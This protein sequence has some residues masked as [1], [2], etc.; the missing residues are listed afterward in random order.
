MRHG[1]LEPVT[2]G[3]RA[4]GRIVQHNE[5]YLETT[6]QDRKASGSYYTPDYIVRYIVEQT[7]GPVLE[8]RKALFK[9]Q[10]DSARTIQTALKRNN[11][12]PAV[13]ILHGQL[14]DTHS[15]AIEA[16]LDIKVLDPAM[17]SGHFLV[18]AVNYLSDQIIAILRDYS[19]NPLLPKLA[20]MRGNIRKSLE[21]Q[22]LKAD[23]V[24]D[25]KLKD[26]VLLRRMVMK[27]CIYGVDLND[28]AVELAKLSL[29]L[30]SFAVGAPLS[31]LDHH[32]RW[33]NSLIG[34]W[35]VEINILPAMGYW[36]EFMRALS[37]MVSITKLTDSTND[38]VHE[39][40][41]LYKQAQENLRPF[42]ER[43]NVDLARHFID[44]GDKGKLAQ[45]QRVARDKP[46]ERAGKHD[47]A[48]I[49][50]FDMAQQ[51]AA[52]RRFFHWKLEFPEVFIDHERSDWK[53]ESTSGFDAVVGNPP[54]IRESGN[55]SIFSYFQKSD[56][57]LQYYQ[58]KTDIYFYFTIQALWL[59]NE[60]GGLGYIIPAN[61]L[62]A[63]SSVKLRKFL[64]DNSQIQSIVVF[65][66]LQVF[67]DAAVE[68]LIIITNKRGKADTF[69]YQFRTTKHI[70]A[71]D[72]IL[73]PEV[74]NI[75][76]SSL[77]SDGWY[78]KGNS[79]QGIDTIVERLTLLSLNL[80]EFFHVEAGVNTGA[81]YV[82]TR[83][84]AHWPSGIQQGQ[85]IFV[86]DK[87]ELV[88]IQFSKIERNYIR[89]YIPPEYVDRYSQEED[90][91][92]F[93][94]YLKRDDD[95]ENLPYIKN[96]LSKFKSI[97]ENRAEILRNPSRRWWHLLWPR[98]QE[99]YE[100]PEKLVIANATA[101]NSFYVDSEQTYYNI[102][103]T[104]LSILANVSIDTNYAAA[105][106]NAKLLD[107]WYELRGQT[108]AET[109]RKYFPDKVRQIPIRR[110]H[111]TTPAARRTALAA[112][113]TAEALA[114]AEQERTLPLEHSASGWPRYDA[115]AFRSA[116][117]GKRIAALLPQDTQGTFLAFADGAT[118]S[119]EQSDVVHDLLAALAKRMIDLNKQKQAE[120]KRFL[121]DLETKL[122]ITT[123][124]NGRTGIDS[125]NKK[126]T[127]Q[128]YLGDYQK[129]EPAQPWETICAVLHKN[130]KRFV[131]DGW[132]SNQPQIFEGA[133][134]GGL[135]RL[136]SEYQASLNKLRPIKRQL[137]RT[138]ALIDQIVYMLY[139]L[140]LEEI[141]V[142][143]A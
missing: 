68:P 69:L 93:L 101:R 120:I 119:E 103:C 62:E 34:I 129:N 70:R 35:D 2:P 19:D 56:H 18:A 15:A 23:S 87:E 77:K 84:R 128:N 88:Q 72:V 13:R 60:C 54:Y 78:L 1:K 132:L 53:A 73:S 6:R 33:G 49:A 113:L 39:S 48:S 37:A 30:D 110:I 21:A 50:R 130:R 131:N 57:F 134:S 75:P 92:H 105:L 38:E 43:F 125:L 66:G 26:T 63:V 104:V 117:L 27:R 3:R 28:M 99:V 133:V 116:P 106:L 11:D 80:G 83:S 16:L 126:R 7:V 138:D 45:A 71:E 41:E 143:E 95:I 100:R 122:D 51:E 67:E 91:N 32:L 47:P 114:F 136:Q 31:F 12:T 98:E 139:G 61:W 86:I 8:V 102:G 118:G 82:S 59:A 44:M 90:D 96:H 46:E 124:K 17:G 127:I 5:V 24:P 65:R 36:K 10:M 89:K 29:W 123:D 79:I 97:L 76:I 135:T 52:E 42:R 40:Q 9:Q 111:F 22:G 81:D 140:T 112:E 74:I 142:V 20:S 137:A 4:S 58:G 109:Q 108:Q 107:R 64:Q 25:E 14:E 55:K 85:G 94:I 115:A 141:A 121:S